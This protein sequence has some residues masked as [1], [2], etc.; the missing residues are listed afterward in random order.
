M[1]HYQLSHKDLLA[2]V[3]YYDHSNNLDAPYARYSKGEIGFSE[4]IALLIN[5]IS[6]AFYPIMMDFIKSGVISLERALQLKIS[7]L[8]LFELPVD[9]DYIKI[10]LCF[11]EILRI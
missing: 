6:I 8:Y 3:N 5:K 4:A 11:F 10:N 2:L 1:D 7:Q 9:R